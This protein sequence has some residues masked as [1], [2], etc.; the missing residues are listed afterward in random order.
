MAQIMQCKKLMVYF[1]ILVIFIYK[2]SLIKNATFTGVVRNATRSVLAAQ[3][4]EM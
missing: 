3:Q 1:S 4:I 2:S